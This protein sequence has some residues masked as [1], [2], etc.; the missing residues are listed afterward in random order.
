MMNDFIIPPVDQDSYFRNA[1]FFQYVGSDRGSQELRAFISGAYTD[2]SNGI[3]YLF[4]S[5]LDAFCLDS[6]SGVQLDTAGRLIG[7][8]RPTLSQIGRVGFFGF[9][10]LPNQG[11]DFGEFQDGR[12]ISD[13]L[14]S[15]DE[16]RIFLKIKISENIWDGTRIGL[17]KLLMIATGAEKIQIENI[18]FSPVENNPF[19]LDGEEGQGFD[20]GQ[21]DVAMSSYE[22]FFLDAENEINGFDNGT[23]DVGVGYHKPANFRIIF[24][25]GV[26]QE[27]VDALLL[28]NI[29]PTPQGIMLAEVLV[30]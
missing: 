2:S 3:E 30:A 22:P 29:I 23:F 8:S 7:L 28:L 26:T 19:I 17:K 6:I 5:I 13:A 27:D 14:V 16:Y 24:T 25:G 9:D 18:T 12:E 1:I 4:Q 10:D 15:D 11:F 20:D 21:F